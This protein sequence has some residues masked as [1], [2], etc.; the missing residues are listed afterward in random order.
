VDVIPCRLL[1]RSRTGED[2]AGVCRRWEAGDGG[3]SAD[4]ARWVVE[5]AG[6]DRAENVG[7]KPGI[8]SESGSVAFAI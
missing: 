1:E 8:S 6:K 7:D 3:E 4:I 5:Q 2:R